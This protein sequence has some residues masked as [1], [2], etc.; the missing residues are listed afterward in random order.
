MITGDHRDTALAIG[1][2]LQLATDRRQVITG[3]E[4]AQINRE[5]LKHKVDGFNIFARVSP[6]HKV[7]IVDALKARGEIVA[8]TGDGVND[9]PALKR[10]DIGIA[11][12]KTGTD[13]ARGAAEMILA[14]DNFATIVGAVREGRVIFENI[15]KTIYFL[16]SCNGGEILTIL[17]AI[18]FRWPLPL[19]PI[20]ILW[21]NLVTDSLPALALGIEAADEVMKSSR[22]P[23]EGISG[24]AQ[25]DHV[26]FSI[27]RPNRPDRLPSRFKPIPD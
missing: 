19:L 16:L 25:A 21:I 14:D 1:R 18:L 6:E 3:E 4:L 7:Q 13:V 24:P 27:N 5:K 2:D 23:A 12:G 20:Q 11:M 15:R 9:A 10:A 17:A 8:M 26:A 22:D